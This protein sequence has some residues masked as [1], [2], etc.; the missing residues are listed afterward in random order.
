MSLSVKAEYAVRIALEIAAAGASPDSPT[1]A[2]DLADAQA[3]SRPFVSNTVIPALRKAG[4]VA[5]RRG[6]YGGYWLARPPSEISI[7]DVIRCVQDPIVSVA[8]KDPAQIRYSGQV[9]PL[10]DLWLQLEAAS[11][12]LLENV[13][14][15]AVVSGE[16]HT[17][18]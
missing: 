18:L 4:I 2:D 12:E 16:P 11:L 9:A 15:A 5:S 17:P 14:L 13:S 6:Y 7:A 3:M 1:K 8:G 10:R